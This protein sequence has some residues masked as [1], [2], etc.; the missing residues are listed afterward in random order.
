MCIACHHPEKFVKFI[1]VSERASNGTTIKPKNVQS[2]QPSQPNQQTDQRNCEVVSKAPSQASTAPS[3]PSNSQTTLV[4]TGANIKPQ[5][6]LFENISSVGIIRAYSSS[7]QKQLMQEEE[8]LATPY[9]MTRSRS[10][11]DDES[12]ALF[13][14]KIE[15]AEW[16]DSDVDQL[17]FGN[18]WEPQ[19][20]SN[21]V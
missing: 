11:S 17:M 8:D 5:S 12:L 14:E 15:S 9:P 2:W 18:P 6:I 3:S 10:L 20:Q 1:K 16:N 13:V 7:N 19:V 21:N 4:P